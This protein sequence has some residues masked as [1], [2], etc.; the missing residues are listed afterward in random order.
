M[1]KLKTVAN[2]LLT[3]IVFWIVFLLT[4]LVLFVHLFERYTT[5]GIDKIYRLF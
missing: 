3:N 5:F 1:K 4:S 2:A